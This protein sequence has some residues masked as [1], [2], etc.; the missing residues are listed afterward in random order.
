MAQKKYAG[1]EALQ[2]F[3]ENL[4]A[5]FATKTEVA[6]KSQVQMIT[7]EADD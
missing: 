5:L 6:Q 7:W 4:K 2:T 3:L 1:L